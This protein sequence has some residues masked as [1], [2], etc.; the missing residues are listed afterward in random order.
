MRLIALIALAV[1]L[2]SA[3]LLAIDR[4]IMDGVIREADERA[5]TALAPSRVLARIQAD[6]ERVAVGNS[7]R[8]LP[9]GIA[10]DPLE[11]LVE[12]VE[13]LRRGRE[14]LVRDHVAAIRAEALRRLTLADESRAATLSQ[15]LTQPRNASPLLAL[16]LAL[17]LTDAALAAE[18]SPSQPT[19]FRWRLRL[20]C[21][22]VIGRRAGFEDAAR[23]LGAAAGTMLSC[24]VAETMGQD[25][26]ALER[27]AR[28]PSTFAELPPPSPPQPPRHEDHPP[29]PPWD[30]AAAIR[31]MADNPELVEAPLRLAMLES[32][33]ARLDLA[34]FL[35]AF[36]DPSPARDD[37]IRTLVAGLDRASLAKADERMLRFSG[38]PRPYDGSDESLVPSLRLAAFTRVADVTA[39][40]HRHPYAL[41]CAVLQR[42]PELAA[43]RR[44]AVTPEPND[45]TALPVP[46]LSGCLIGRG[47]VV[48]FPEAALAAFIDGTTAALGSVP[49]RYPLPLSD[50]PRMEQVMAEPRA[51][52]AEPPPPLDRPY[53]TWA[54]ASLR[55]AAI[56][57]RL[58]TLFETARTGLV[59]YYRGMGLDQNEAEAAAR[60]ALFALAPGSMCGNAPPP[61]SLRRQIMDGAPL[62]AIIAALDP[63]ANEDLKPFTDCAATAPFAPLLH[64]AVDRPAVLALLWDVA[65]TMSS[66]T[67]PEGSSETDPEG[68]SHLREVNSRDSLGGTALMA[69]AEAG[70]L[71]SVRFLLDHG[72]RVNADRWAP[73]ARQP[74]PAEQSRT[75]LM[76]AAATGSLAMI[77]MLLDAGADRFQADGAGLRAIDHLLGHAGGLANQTLS[78]NERAEAARLLF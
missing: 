6:M 16:S 33:T 59:D 17:R 20:P 54:Y 78:A 29:S 26:A 27:L 63:A 38:Q 77:T 46:A 25:V 1:L 52:L 71:N 23:T 34:L 72:A 49:P 41:P 31:F 67:D 8:P 58:H 7:P 40:R 36:R 3:A 28:R 53:Q 50:L 73:P 66:E 11:R 42:R 35:H 12:A 44:L 45:G 76:Q 10:R 15:T 13:A 75:A 9:P 68:L 60:Q 55:Q 4:L 39:G 19:D 18:D 43:A 22:L 30:H 57:Q 32:Q 2:G 14:T 51:L 56:T 47:K 61:R 37:D 48:G 21:R 74:T 64:V 70:K 24:P 69:A 5:D 65:A 62:D